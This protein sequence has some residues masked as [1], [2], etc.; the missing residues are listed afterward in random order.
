MRTTPKQPDAAAE[1]KQELQAS[2][3]TA[4][5]PDDITL[6]VGATQA[7]S[8]PASPQPV[9]LRQLHSSPRAHSTDDSD[10]AY[11]PP[12][13]QP[14]A[15]KL[16]TAATEPASSATAEPKPAPS[17]PALGREPASG[18]ESTGD[19]RTASRRRS[20]RQRKVPSLLMQT[21]DGYAR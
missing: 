1:R 7:F 12:P 19:D 4:G 9:E 20:D 3:V 18:E 11:L 17:T 5:D 15:A 10:E 14:A 6:N 13:T 16:V 2:K 21:Q 8:P